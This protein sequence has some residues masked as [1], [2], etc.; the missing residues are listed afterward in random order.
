M[1][2]IF[3]VGTCDTK[4]EELSFVKSELSRLGASALLVDVGT[5]SQ[6]SVADVSA[7]AVAASHPLGRTAVLGLTDRGEAVK[8]MGEA[9]IAY[10][11]S[12]DDVGG[13]I[14]LGG[15]G[16]TS[17]VT[18]A[19]RSLPLGTP[20][21]MVSTVASGDVSPYVGMSDICMISPVTDIAGLNRLNRVVLRNAAHAIAG[22]V[23]HDSRAAEAHELPA[24]GIT[25]FGVT[26]PCVDE[27]RRRL[28]DSRECMVFHATG[29]G[30]Q[31]MERLLEGRM[32]QGLLDV[33]TTE[34]ADF[35]VGGVL[36]CTP[37]RFGATIR[38]QAPCVVSCGA[39]DMVNFGPEETLPSQFR[40]RRLYRHNP[41]VTLMRTSPEESSRIGAWIAARLNLCEGPVRMILPE[42]GV[43]AL[44]AVDQPF[45]D[46]VADRALFD[47]IE[48]GLR[49]NSHRRLEI[50][51]FHINEGGFAELVCKRF[52]EASAVSASRGVLGYGQE[53]QQHQGG[54]SCT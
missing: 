49:T 17:L 24:V 29:V 53:A 16:N 39:L 27:L 20:K 52:F 11:A 36:P 48:G 42:K 22:M 9:L 37:D 4:Q 7:Q 18:S 51:P 44:D 35:I 28:A 40:R 34:V 25:Q 26:T 12:R 43:S 5:R 19:M 6:R 32:L 30:G 41:Q 38:T 14:G 47:A 31:I 45:Y 8:A 50:A 10:L 15:G 21:V 1:N 3:V 2:K 54:L 33:T 23:A 13:I 46:P